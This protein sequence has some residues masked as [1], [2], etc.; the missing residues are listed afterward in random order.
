MSKDKN[1][2]FLSD[3]SEW[4]TAWEQKAVRELLDQIGMRTR[5]G[6]ITLFE[7]VYFSDRYQAAR[8]ASINKLIGNS[9]VFD[10]FH[11][12][13]SISPDSGPLLRKIV[14]IKDCFFRIRVSHSG[15]ESLLRSSGLEDLV[16]RIPIGLQIEWFP[17]K[18]RDSRETR[19]KELGIPSSAVV[20]GSFQKDGDPGVRP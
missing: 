9:G 14:D 18:T 15:M 8:L 6:R 10:Y 5:V 17:P 3:R 1:I 4:V 12:D 13:P 20:V 19:R 2:L 7:K 16:F 11:G